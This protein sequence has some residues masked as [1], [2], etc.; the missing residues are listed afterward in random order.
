MEQEEEDFSTNKVKWQIPLVLLIHHLE[1]FLDVFF[2]IVNLVI[3]RE[4][5]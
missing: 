5:E 1:L 3:M 4:G 2:F